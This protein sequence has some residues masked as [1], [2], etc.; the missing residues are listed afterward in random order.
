M[1]SDALQM[2]DSVHRSPVMALVDLPC[3]EDG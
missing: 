1:S 3:H 2:I